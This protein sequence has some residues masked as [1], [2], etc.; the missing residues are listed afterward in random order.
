MNHYVYLIVNNINNK[1]YI[2]KR[3]CS[4]PIEQD[5]Y[6]G[7][8]KALKQAQKKYGIENFTKHILLVCDSEEQAYIEEEKAIELAGA[9]ESDRYYNIAYGGKGAGSGERNHF[10]GK[11]HSEETRE[12][13]KL[14]SKDKYKG[15]NNPMYGV[16]PLERVK[17]NIEKYK[18]WC[19]KISKAN[20]G[21]NNPNYGKTP[22]EETRKK[23][24][25]AVKGEKHPFYNKPC[26]ET[27]RENISKANKGK[28]F[29]KEHR[30]NISKA[31]MG[32]KL[33]EEHKKA[34]RD[35]STVKKAIVCLNTGVIFGSI[36]DASKEYNIKHQ[37]ISACCKGDL[38]SA[39][40]I[41]GIRLVWK[42]K[43]EYEKLT[44]QQ[45]QN[46]IN[47]AQIKTKGGK[48]VICI[49]TLEIFNTVADASREYN[50]KSDETISRCCKGKQKSAG[51]HPETGK[52]LVWMYLEDYENK[53]GAVA[54]K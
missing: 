23:I 30:E 17:N 9:V 34:I 11:R 36:T 49:N 3:S 33:S 22:S 39:G 31:R 16:T 43:E 54:K 14:I 2:G 37:S 27:R 28:V 46:I 51:K 10:Y 25:D 44:T 35:A 5:N 47:I 29:T 6:M 41:E 38:Y 12:Y 15:V 8:G 13:L 42:Y 21:A 32:M 45:I 19:N 52:K 26:S 50:I 18:I 48:A 40:E 24:S 7:S 20:S 4:C 53:Y 1:K